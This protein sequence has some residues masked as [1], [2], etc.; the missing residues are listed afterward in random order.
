MSNWIFNL[1]IPSNRPTITKMSKIGKKV[2]FCFSYFEKWFLWLIY[3]W[4]IMYKK[5]PSIL[6]ACDFLLLLS[7]ILNTF[8]VLLCS[9]LLNVDQFMIVIFGWNLWFGRIAEKMLS[10][11]KIGVS[12]LDIFSLIS[13]NWPLILKYMST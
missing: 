4:K 8:L 5:K 2:N 12:C 7:L 13:T 10:L 6:L 1:F 3:D 11:V 9:K